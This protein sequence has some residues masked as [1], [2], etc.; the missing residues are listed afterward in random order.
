MQLDCF[1]VFFNRNWSSK[2]CQDI[3]EEIPD[4]LASKIDQIDDKYKLALVSGFIMK[5]F[6]EVN[7]QMVSDHRHQ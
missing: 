7:R 2:L 4:A 6:S 1:T 3:L 5:F